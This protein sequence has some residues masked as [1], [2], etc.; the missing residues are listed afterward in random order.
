MRGA[1]LE[2]R[3]IENKHRQHSTVSCY[4]FFSPKNEPSREKKKEISILWKVILKYF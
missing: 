3:E 1:D 4:T 2:M